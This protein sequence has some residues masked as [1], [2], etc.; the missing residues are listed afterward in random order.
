M[1]DKINGYDNF[2]ENVDREFP[3]FMK[4]KSD[5]NITILNVNEIGNMGLFSMT[6]T[7]SES[8]FGSLKF[9]RAEKLGYEVPF[10][11]LRLFN[12]RLV[13]T[14][15]EVHKI[16]R[17]INGHITSNNDFIKATISQ[18][19]KV[20]DVTDDTMIQFLKDQLMLILTSSNKH[21]YS[22]AIITLAAELLCVSPAAYRM[23]RASRAIFLPKEQFIHD[24]MSRSVN[25]ENVRL[26]MEDLQPNQRLVNI[27]FDEVKL[28]S[29]L[30]FLLLTLMQSS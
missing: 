5:N 14:W 22:K 1:R 17:V 15:T 9:L 2:V 27:V 12:H 23:V 26:V 29:A 13:Y 10:S 4:K 16:V 30:C 8:T 20:V 6:F 28:K 21:H 7:R 24:L 25:E 11:E 3:D 18:L 19:E